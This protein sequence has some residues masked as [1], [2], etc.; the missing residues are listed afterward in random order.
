MINPDVNSMQLKTHLPL[1]PTAQV[2]MLRVY[3]TCIWNV[4]KECLDFS[5]NRTINLPFPI[6]RSSFTLL[7]RHGPLCNVTGGLIQSGP[8]TNNNGIGVRMNNASNNGPCYTFS[9]YNNDSTITGNVSCETETVVVTYDGSTCKCYV[10]AVLVNT[11]TYTF[12]VTTPTNAV[13]GQ[14]WSERSLGKICLAGMRKRLFK[15]SVV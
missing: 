1:S 4:S 7:F 2:T 11:F 10:N 3:V 8:L 13:I 9:R 6:N 14:M 5:T 12:S 15:R